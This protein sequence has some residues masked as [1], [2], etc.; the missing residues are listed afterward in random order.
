MGLLG[1]DYPGYFPVGDTEALAGLIG[2]AESDDNFYQ[3]LKTV[4][5]A[6]ASLF[7]PEAE[8]KAWQKMLDELTE[9]QSS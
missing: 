7:S 2:R 4:S 3:E 6:V 9:E 8:Q 5:A 1:E